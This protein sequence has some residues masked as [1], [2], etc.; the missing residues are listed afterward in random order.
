MMA[1]RYRM[2]DNVAKALGHVAVAI[3]HLEPQ[4]KQKCES[5]TTLPAL[6]KELQAGLSAELDSK[7]SL[8]EKKLTLS[9]PAQEKLDNGA[10]QV[11]QAAES[12]KSSNKDM[13]SS[14][15]QVMDMNDQL[16]CTAT[17]Y[18]DTLLKSKEQQPRLQRSQE[19]M[20]TDPKI[21]RDVD[22]KT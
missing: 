13:G 9:L 3:H 7:L 6:I 10:K 1:E 5:T 16:A 4:Q 8:L 19:P 20:Q 21:L 11:E 12:I 14:I 15:A 22:R 17:S 18:K 2:P